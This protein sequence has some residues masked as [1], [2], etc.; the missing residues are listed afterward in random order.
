MKTS[1]IRVIIQLIGIYFL[2]NYLLT[3]FSWVWLSVDFEGFD[4][5][6]V[7]VVFAAYFVI[8]RQLIIKPDGIIKFLGLDNES[9]SD[10]GLRPSTQLLI[11]AVALIGFFIVVENAGQLFSQTMFYIERKISNKINPLEFY[12]YDRRSWVYAGISVLLGIS[13]IIKSRA[14]TNWIHKNTDEDGRGIELP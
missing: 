6:R 11:T 8:F 9:E 13:I 5:I 10:S 12:G 14:I 4:L 1:T 2:T 3:S 7:L